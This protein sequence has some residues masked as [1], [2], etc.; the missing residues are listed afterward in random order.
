MIIGGVAA[1]MS[2][3]SRAK[4]FDPGAEV[5]VFERGEYISYGACGLPYVIGG[6]VEDFDDLIARTP[7]RM[8][9]QG[10]SVRTG[11]EV[12]GVDAKAGTIT[13]LD[14]AAGRTT[15][16]PFD[17][18]LIATG[19][20]AVR[21][22]WA[23]TPPAQP[24]LGGVHV[25]RDI[26]DG[27]AI[28]AS[29]QGANG[30]P[31]KRACIV[32]GGYIGLEMAEALHARGL[33]VILLE[34]GPEVAG[35]MLDKQL[36]HRVRAELEAKGVEVRCGTAVEGLTGEHHVT[37]VQ[38]SG[39]LVRADL[40][41]V[42]VGVRPNTELA[43]AAGARIG[44]TGAVAV[45]I[46]QETSVPGIYAAG[47]NTESLHG[48]T[49]RKV[50]IPL[51]LTANR[52]GR[53]AGVNMAGGDATFPGIVGT[54]IFKVFDLGV[55]RTGLTQA[56]ADALGLKAASVDVDSTD[57]AGYYNDSQPIHVRLTAEVGTG[58][59]LG[60]QLVS[61]RH[62]SVKRVDVVAALLHRRSTVQHLFDTDLAYAPPFSG[63]WDV[64]LV[65]AD[66]LNRKIREA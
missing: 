66:K 51:G 4:R 65:A 39:G 6:E 31:P 48:V 8:R 45:N 58:R 49:K 40:V 16:E 35:R 56:E 12:T 42:A 19:V 55:A 59:L 13:V 47:D 3:A 21:P 41:I 34:K 18:L 36:Q 2:A 10:I 15:T 20:R 17:R 44:K 32:G 46:R 9:G 57:H 24:P 61:P 26:P 54:A 43:Q 53:V 64:L 5:V 1:G 63:V 11:H 27:Q 62:I 52:M 29:L 38:T 37:G 22:D 30:K 33:S 23:Q 50:H 28:E 7:E 25:L 60:V 14:R